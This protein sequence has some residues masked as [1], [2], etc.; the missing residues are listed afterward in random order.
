M[1]VIISK[2]PA[3]L[4]YGDFSSCKIWRLLIHLRVRVSS[5][6]RLGRVE[7]AK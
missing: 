5:V 6:G 4:T 2:Q 3:L 1:F 7:E